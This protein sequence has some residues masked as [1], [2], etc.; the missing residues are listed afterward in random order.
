MKLELPVGARSLGQPRAG[1]YG[2]ASELDSC[3]PLATSARLGQTERRVC[4]GG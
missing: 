3:T 4:G 2:V 1:G